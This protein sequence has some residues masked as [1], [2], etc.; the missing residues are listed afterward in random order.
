MAR[1]VL[2]RFLISRP[3]SSYLKTSVAVHFVAHFVHVEHLLCTKARQSS[4]VP[5]PRSNLPKETSPDVRAS[6]TVE[7][8]V[9]DGQVNTGLEC[10]VEVLEAIGREEHGSFV[11]FQ[12]SKK[13]FATC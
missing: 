9:P 7:R 6:V 2:S 12:E 5:R 3:L 1:A 4:F 13:H 8:F 10:I 11:V